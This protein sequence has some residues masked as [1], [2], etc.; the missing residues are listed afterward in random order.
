VVRAAEDLVADSGD[1]RAL[2]LECANL[3]PYAAAVQAA[4]SLPVYDFTTM[5][6]QVWSALVR[7]PFDPAG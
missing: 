3:P 5:L 2:L 6:G 7:R 1:I 4:V